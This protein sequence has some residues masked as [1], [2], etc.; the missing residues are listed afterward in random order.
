MEKDYVLKKLMDKENEWWHKQLYTKQN[1]CDKKE[2]ACFTRHMTSDENLD[3]LVKED[4][5]AAMKMVFK[6]PVWKAQWD[7]YEKHYR[8]LVAEEKRQEQEVT[9]VA[10]A[11][12]RLQEWQRK[13]SKKRQSQEGRGRDRRQLR[14]QVKIQKQV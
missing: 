6:K 13:D 10:K 11:A 5:A 2:R 7:K 9:R 8:D 1:K 4:W 3:I 12:E 14:D